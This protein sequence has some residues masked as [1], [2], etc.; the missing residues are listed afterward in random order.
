M[1]LDQLKNKI[2]LA[3]GDAV[4]IADTVS[5]KGGAVSVIRPFLSDSNPEIRLVAVDC[6]SII[7]H[8]E[9]IKLMAHMLS[10]SFDRIR[11]I[12]LQTLYSNHDTSILPQL[13]TNLKNSDPKI[14]SGV[15]L[16]IGYIGNTS[17]VPALKKQIEIEEREKVKRDQILALGRLGDRDAQKTIAEQ[18]KIPD[19]VTRMK[20]IEDIR[21][22][23][24]K[25]I[26]PY[27]YYA[28]DDYGKGKNIG[29][30]NK[31]VYARVLDEAITLA[32]KLMGNPF[33]FSIKEYELYTDE[34]RTEARTKL[35]PLTK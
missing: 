32:A 26:A 5:D 24:D 3:D 27:L 4:S 2:A 13:I 9:S 7:Q 22:I 30:K 20:I 28:M 1:E 6:L 16:I 11:T 17:A 19:S 12:A 10:D 23:N 25:R 29:S 34:E 35:E 31:P 15:A 14:A 18:I 33:S 8:P 21:Y